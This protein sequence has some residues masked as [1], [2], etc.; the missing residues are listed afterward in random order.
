MYIYS[1]RIYIYIEGDMYIDSIRI[2]IYIKSMQLNKRDF[3]Y[4]AANR[5]T[6]SSDHWLA[7]LV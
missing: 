4:L 7:R 3:F 2:Y 1:I 6:R 5:E